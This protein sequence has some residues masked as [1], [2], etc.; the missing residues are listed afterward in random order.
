MNFFERIKGWFNRMFNAST[1]QSKIGINLAISD[2][3]QNAI[4]LW[5]REYLNLERKYKF[6]YE[7]KTLRLQKTISSELARMIT[8]EN[9]IKITGENS[10]AEF[11]DAAFNA[12]R[13]RLRTETE[14]WQA[15]GGLVIKPYFYDGQLG[16]DFIQQDKFMPIEFDTNGI[17][18]SAIFFEQRKVGKIF[19]TRCEVHRRI[20]IN[21]YAIE[22]MA[23]SSY[24]EENLGEQVPLTD[25]SEWAAIEP[26]VIISDCP[27]P[28]FTYIRTPYANNID[29]LSRLGIS[30]FANV[31][32][33]IYDADEQYSR[34][35]WEFEGGE[36]AVH[37]S[38]DLFVK[39]KYK[40][41]KLDEYVYNLPKGKNRLYKVFN[42][43]P[44]EQ[45]MQTFSPALR[46]LNLINGLNKILQEIEI[47]CGLSYGTLSDTTLLEGRTATEINML[48]QRSYSTI[49]DNQKA[50]EAGLKELAEVVDIYCDLYNLAPS[51]EWE[52]ECHWDDSI[53]VDIQSKLQEMAQ[54]KA[55]GVVS[56]EEIRQWYFNEDEET[57]KK[58]A[59]EIREQT[60]FIIP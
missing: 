35:M 6:G 45:P 18:Q 40:N 5:K 57:A 15:L 22:N 14:Y 36:L 12:V 26:S 49:S 23:Y 16:L 25:I 44:G 53:I 8:I 28:L 2:S 50:L 43:S 54:L 30:C 29:E 39:S 10:R 48:K 1:I 58:R 7:Q 20:A 52:M 13:N 59:A 24:N 4:L 19:Y 9:E 32:N 42:A 41:A 21:K 60:Q 37:A 3:M 31:D 17:L 51:G 47:G 55:L 38:S 56:A 27:R 34:L 11:I 46:D 33:L